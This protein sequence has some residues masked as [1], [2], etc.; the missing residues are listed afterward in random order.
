MV[1]VNALS[2]SNVGGSERDMSIAP[3]MALPGL[4]RPHERRRVLAEC[5][6]LA[7]EGEQGRRMM[8]RAGTISARSRTIEALRGAE[9]Q[10]A[11]TLG[12]RFKRA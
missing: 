1:G 7:I 11:Q 12:E 3:D 9:W 5:A 6:R 4:N 10:Q 2:A 8:H